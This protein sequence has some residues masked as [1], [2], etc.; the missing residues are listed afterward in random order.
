MRAI[1]IIAGFIIAFAGI[2]DAVA[3]PRH[4]HHRQTHHRRAH[5]THEQSKAPQPPPRPPAARPESFDGSCVFSGAVKFTPP[6]TSTPQHVA[7]HADAPGT[8]TGT[9][10]DQY[11]GTH[12]YQ[13]T[14][15]RDMSESAGDYVSCEF[16]FATGAGTLTFPDGEIWFTM[17]EYRGGATPMIRFDGKNGGGSWMLVTP[18]QKSDP[19]AALQACGGPGL[20]EFDLDG[21]LQT[22]QPIT[23]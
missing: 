17:T 16:G 6:M 3:K 2:G 7:Q 11:G 15:A 14:P 23:G 18:S 13:D 1:A 12:G 8:C 5:R 20:D 21:H 4:K 19:V 9:F 10:V 22:D